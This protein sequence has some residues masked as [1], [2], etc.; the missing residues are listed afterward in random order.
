MNIVTLISN[1]FISVPQPAALEINELIIQ[2]WVA[3]YMDS[4]LLARSIF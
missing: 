2:T 1:A 3:A 4:S